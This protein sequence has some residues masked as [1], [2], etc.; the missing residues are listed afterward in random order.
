[1]ISKVHP[2]LKQRVVKQENVDQ[3]THKNCSMCKKDLHREQF[4][5]D[6]SRPSGLRSSCRECDSAHNRLK[7]KITDNKASDQENKKLRVMITELTKTLEDIN[8]RLLD[9]EALYDI[10]NIVPVAAITVANMCASEQTRNSSENI[11]HDFDN[12][13]V[14][15]ISSDS[16]YE[17]D[18]NTSEVSY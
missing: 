7:R 10:N 2:L 13:V 16:S 3:T 9:F 15:D 8:Q 11:E 1:M 5:S 6:K 17:N 18:V 4:S 14:S 12:V